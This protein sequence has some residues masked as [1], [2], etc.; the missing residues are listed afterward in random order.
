MKFLHRL[1]ALFRKEKLDHQ[2]GDELAFHLDKQI[3][4]N[5]AAGMRAEEA[6]YAALRKFGG[7]E[8]VK[9]ECRDAWGARFIGALLQDI[10]FAL[11][12]LR[13]NPSF[14]AVAIITLAVG[15]GANTAIFSLADVFMF[16]PL[17][18]RD[19]DRLTVVAVQGKADSD[20]GEISYPDYLEYRAG[21]SGVFTGMTGYDLDIVGLS[22]Q[23]HA[24]RLIISY[25]P[26]NFF[27]MLGIRPA[28][29]RLI[30]PGEGDAPGTA[31]VVVLGHTYWENRFG[32]D[33]GVIG[34]TVRFNGAP[35]SVIGVVPKDFLGPYNVVEMDAYAPIGMQGFPTPT[36]FFTS[37]SERDMRGL[38]TLKP[39]VSIEQ[40]QAVLNVIGHRLA[41]E[42]PQADQGQRVRVFPERIARPEPAVADSMP[43]VATVF[44]A[45][46]GLVLVV[47]CLNVANLLLARAA[48]REKEISIRAAMGAGRKR[49]LRQLLTESIL[50]AVAGALGGAVAGNWL[51]RLLNGVRPLGNFPLH[52]AFAFDWRVFA[53]VAG[54]ALAAGILAGL[55][56][57]LRVSRIDLNLALREGGRGLVGESG[58]HRLRNGLVIAQ[59]AGSMIVLVSAGLFTRSLTRAESVD[60]GFDPHYVLNVSL[61][62]G[63]QGYPQPRAEALLAEVLRRAQS[64]PGVQS[65]SLAF[66]VPLGIYQ[67]GAPVYAEGQAPA[68]GHG[69]P[70]VGFNRVSPDY[71]TTLG[72][73]LFEGRAFTG[74]DTATSEPVAIINQ[75]MA[76]HLWPHRDALGQHFSYEAASGPFVAVVGVA[77][78]VKN[79]DLLHAPGMYFYVPQ[80]Q[81]YRSP[82]VLQMRTAVPPESL[83]PVVEGLVRQLDPNLPVYDVMSMEKALQGANGFFLFKA[84]ALF[85]GALG[86]L[87]LLLAVVGVYGVV[88]YS[89]SRRRHEIGVRLAL[90]A[91]RA[92]IFRLV[93]GQGFLLVTAGIAL[94]I[95]AALGVSR[96]VVS[97]LVGVSSYD[98]LTF[99]GAAAL[100]MAVALLACYLPARRATKVDPMVALRYE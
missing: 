28:L 59:V 17:P 88:S 3:E 78:D 86:A 68:P 29:G 71:F 53:Y 73:H 5:L 22:Y 89:A 47:A 75:S 24:D 8:Q 6:R 77:H 33:P 1:R 36:S 21:T 51:C 34:R 91:Q 69:V 61:D 43:L 95:V 92:T 65:A 60:L 63:L 50:L 42:Y 54:A 16:R 93:I 23:G 80:T 98:P 46:V 20:P 27:S 9:E 96:L 84:G 99:I 81:N 48:A 83:A 85:A 97:L 79:A 31:P 26:S 30:E 10:R 7:V 35:V 57:A 37:R 19:A 12:M 100:L 11:R 41:Q 49:L 94:G 45:M 38:A 25:V 55:V 70:N 4:Q 2:L 18:V 87:G 39:G 66:S 64:L 74:A 67:D 56:P 52:L 14:T 72:I 90:G 13:K 40:A 82:H 76:E 15:I 58:G 62:P 44:L 32:G